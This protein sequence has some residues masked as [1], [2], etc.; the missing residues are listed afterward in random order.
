MIGKE[1]RLVWKRLQKL[2]PA[3]ASASPSGAFCGFAV[4]ARFK[5]CDQAGFIFRRWMMMLPCSAAG[6]FHSSPAKM[7][8]SGQ[9]RRVSTS[10]A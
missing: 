5:K 10:S 6:M 2:T 9:A 7:M 4:K 8:I 1:Q 3:M